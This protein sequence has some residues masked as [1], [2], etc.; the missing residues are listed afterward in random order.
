MPKI[1]RVSSPTA[2]SPHIFIA[3]PSYGPVHPNYTVSL[4]KTMLA[5]PAWGVRV[6]YCLLTGD[7]HVDD[8][9]NTCVSEF[10]DRKSVV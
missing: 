6:D 8:S 1:N 10:I 4:T 3:T 2:G 5:L 7:C 9:R